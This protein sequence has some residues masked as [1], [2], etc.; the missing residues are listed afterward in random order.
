M[1]ERMKA[2][3]ETHGLDYLMKSMDEINHIDVIG[4]VHW[5]STIVKD[6]IFNHEFI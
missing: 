3:D 4:H 1:D 2:F 5:N 6:I